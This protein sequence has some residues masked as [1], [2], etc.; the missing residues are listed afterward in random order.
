MVSAQSRQRPSV[1]VVD[2]TAANL[3]LLADILDDVY[4]VSVA[5]S[6]QQALEVLQR[7]NLPD[8]IL[9]DV[10]MPGMD[11]YAVNEAL[12][13]SPQWQQVPVIFV[14]AMSDPVSESKALAAGAVD[15]IHKPINR[16]VVLARVRLHLGLVEHR[17][18]LENLNG[19]L[20][21]SLAEVEQARDDLKVFATVIEQSP[22]AIVITDAQGGV[23]YVNPFFERNSGYMLNE[24]KGL[25]PF[26]GDTQPDETSAQQGVWAHLAA[27]EPWSGELVSRSKAG[28][29]YREDVH[30]APVRDASGNTAHYVSVQMDITARHD[31]EQQVAQ[32][33]QR[34]LEISAAIQQQLLF[35]ALPQHTDSHE[36]ACFTEASQVVDGD[37]YTFTPLGQS[38]FEVLTGDAMG[39]GISAALMGASIKN[40]YREAFNDL[41]I[42]SPG[43]GLPTVAALVNAIHERVSPHLIELGVFVTLCLIR[44]DGA[45]RSLTWVNAGHSPTLISRQNGEVEELLG[46]NLP[47][48][49][50]QSEVYAQQTTPMAAGDTV[51]VFSDGLSEATNADD[52]QY[53]IARIRQMLQDGQ[54]RH[55]APQALLA[56]LKQDVDQFVGEGRVNDDL[57]VLAIRSNPA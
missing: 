22:T 18:E 46:D 44:F 39:K 56:D 20:V 48:G 26:L 4:D 24:V 19:R 45:T 57:T 25:N 42:H 51:L 32:A 33:R 21:R 17:R 28:R 55:L 13:A 50:L 14:T 54:R 5:I 11:G 29:P 34:E 53:G 1:L 16:D 27:G 30:I 49:I 40:A 31:A 41:M 10:M 43:A 36:I 37:F 35:G 7:G 47:L 12:K 23:E 52:E 9:L 38:C 8:L 3:E 6:G 15:F 2:D